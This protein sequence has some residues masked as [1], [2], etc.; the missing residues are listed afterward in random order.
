MSIDGIKSTIEG[1]KALSKATEV[2]KAT[3]T[4]QFGETFGQ[5]F[6]ASLREV[7]GLQKAADN[8]IEGMVLG[9]EGVTA[10]DA[11]IALEKADIAFRLMNQVRMKI[12]RAYEEVMR[13]QL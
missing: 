12:I 13:T 9:K 6:S 8:Q 5:M 7:D 4:K 11:M 1:V 10:H 3:E 2:N